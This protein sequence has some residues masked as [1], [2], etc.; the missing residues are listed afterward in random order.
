MVVW[1]RRDAPLGIGSDVIRAEDYRHV[2]ELDA[3]WQAVA[4]AREAAL[5]KARAEAEAIVAQ[6]QSTA[7]EML[8]Q[9]EQRAQRSAKLGYA[10][11]LRRALEDF[12]ASMAARAYDDDEATRREEDRLV[13]TVM[14]AVEHVVLESD[15]QALFA[16]VAATLGRVLQSQARLTVRVCA[17]EIEPARA[18]FAK[19]VQ[20]GTLN[21]AFEVLADDRA[22]PGHCQCE[23][24]HG[25]ADASLRVQLAA[26]R[27]ALSARRRKPAT[28]ATTQA[29]DAYDDGAFSED[30]V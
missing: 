2:V 4:E 6:A 5:I 3:A 21:A 17:D 30:A 11:G 12:H 15:R 14:Q 29:D 23:W 27:H 1:L 25:V 22:E 26:L 20:A 13:A 16:R 9:A 19:A 18:A 24:D 28:T 7:D 10:A 8:R